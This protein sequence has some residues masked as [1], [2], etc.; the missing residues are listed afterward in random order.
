MK[1]HEIVFYFVFNNDTFVKLFSILHLF[2]FTN[3]TAQSRLLKHSRGGGAKQN[4]TQVLLI[5]SV[6]VKITDCPLECYL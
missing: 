1:Y 6:T 5:A 4:K 2:F 3:V